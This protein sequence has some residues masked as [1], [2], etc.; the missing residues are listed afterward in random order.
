MA[1]FIAIS[2]PAATGKTTLVNSLSTHLEL[3]KAEFS[4]DFHE[5]VLSYLLEGEWFNDVREIVTDV[6]YLCTYLFHLMDYYKKYL[7]DRR[8]HEGIVF[9]D[10]CWIDFSI[11]SIL[12]MWYTRLVKEVQEE[13]LHRLASMNQ[14]ISRVYITKIDDVNYPVAKY[15]S[16]G[17]NS[18]FRLNRPLEAQYYNLASNFK[19]AV[20]LPS[21]DISESSIF[22]LDDLK[23]L[24][25]I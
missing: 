6:D 15:R 23:N 17:K 5:A 14:D 22:I 13:I 25:Y 16:K 18:S 24:G 21:S 7:D 11:Y 10:S 4:P 2:G 9:L 12:N 19:N 20:M 1:T 8:D 3:A